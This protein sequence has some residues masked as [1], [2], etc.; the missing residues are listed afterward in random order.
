MPLLLRNLTL[1]L[2]EGDELLPERL[3]ARFSLA[4]NELLSFSVVRKAIDARKKPHIKFVYTV[5]FTLADEAEFWRQH[6]RDADLEMIAARNPPAFPKLASDRRIIIAG[7]GPAGIFAGLRLAEY[8]L[9]PAILERG[10]P[11]AER[12]QDI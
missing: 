6:S 8:G 10:K 5:E 3:S 9:T 7:M 1:N 4:R 11:V 12:L 2:G